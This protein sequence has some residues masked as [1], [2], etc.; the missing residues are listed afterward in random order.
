MARRLS[1][2]ALIG[3]AGLALAGALLL[4]GLAQ[5]APAAPPTPAPGL[6]ANTGKQL[7]SAKGCIT[8]HRHDGITTTRVFTIDTVPDLT[9]YRRDPAFLRAWL[10]DPAAVRPTTEMPDLGLTD[11]EIE[12]LIAFLNR[13]DEP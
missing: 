7:F 4:A 2:P 6:A 10:K 9:V 1:S 5:A 11:E 12:A 8:C 3:L 13:P